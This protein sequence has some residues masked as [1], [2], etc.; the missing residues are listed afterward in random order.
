MNPAT[1]DRTI[2]LYPEKRRLLSQLQFSRLLVPTPVVLVNDQ[3]IL[4]HP[5]GGLGFAFN[6]KMAITW[7]EIA[8]MYLHTLTITAKKGPKTTHG[9]AILPKDPEGFL[10]RHHVVSLRT[11]PL[12]ALL[13]ATKTPVWIFEAV[14]APVSPE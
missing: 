12:F 6:F 2:A 5:P 3:G 11:F 1:S 4:S 14:I 10:E 9:L 13:P 7:P 8:A